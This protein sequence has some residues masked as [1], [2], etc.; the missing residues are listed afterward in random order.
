MYKCISNGR[1]NLAGAIYGGQETVQVIQ[2]SSIDADGKAEVSVS[3]NGE[4]SVKTLYIHYDCN[5]SRV[6]EQV[7]FHAF[8]RAFPN[9]R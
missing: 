9:E 8:C 4:F 6:T 2:G 5:Q 7:D 3:Q 1:I